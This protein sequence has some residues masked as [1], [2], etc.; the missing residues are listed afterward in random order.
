LGI[1]SGNESHIKALVALF[2]WTV[3]ENFFWFLTISFVSLH[4]ARVGGYWWLGR[5]ALTLF[6]FRRI[7][8]E[9]NLLGGLFPGLCFAK[10]YGEGRRILGTTR[11]FLFE[12][13]KAFETLAEKQEVVWDFYNNLLGTA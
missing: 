10:F 6:Q 3:P 2:G 7:L 4:W 8:N 9:L 12:V 1:A 11:G 13:K 5:G